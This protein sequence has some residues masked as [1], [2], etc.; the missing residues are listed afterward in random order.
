MRERIWTIGNRVFD[1]SRNG[2][3]MGVLN[4]TPD[5]FS[6]GGEFFTSDR[7]IEQ[8]LRM[9]ADGADI[10][11]VGGES[12]RPGSEPID[13]DEEL[14]RVIA[15]I[16]NLRAKIDVP[17]SIDTS[18]AAVARA[19]I[20]VGASIVNDVTGG[21]GDERMLPVVAET[22][23]AL[24]VMHMQ[25]TPR[26]MQVRPRYTDV[27]EEISEFFRQQYA[28]AIGLNIDPMAIAFDPGIGFGKTLEHNLELL[29]RLE[30]LRPHDRPLMVGVS[31]KSLLG[32]LVGS[33]NISDRLVPGLALTSLL[34]ARGAD[35]FRV[36]DVKE[37][38]R[39]LRVAEA[40]L[41]RAK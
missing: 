27:V 5:S 41:Q 30:Q 39:A 1:V 36:H 3:I 2:L 37:N 28:R 23:S 12:T 19:A 16:E 8:G 10:I 35:V 6:D 34:R 9:A 29:A 15:V 24:I 32:K 18:K 38:V 33:P 20:E 22:K 13:A 7:A 4:I 25:G 11:D 40:I 14:R 31:R 17:I 21:R 26:T